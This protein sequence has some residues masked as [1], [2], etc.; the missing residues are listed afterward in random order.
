[1]VKNSKNTFHENSQAVQSHLEITQSAIQRMAENSASC[2]TW[3]VTLVSAILVVIADK[4]K[5][6]YALIAIIPTALFLILDSYYLM[7]EKMFRKSY[8]DFIN[9]LHN[10]KVVET[11]LYSIAPNGN[12]FKMFFTSI[13]SFSVLPFYLTLLVMVW[14]TMSIL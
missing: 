2:K 6:Q 3:C 9:K 4:G 12:R 8:N 14:I 10:D 5:P 11:D 1:M 7:L 13:F